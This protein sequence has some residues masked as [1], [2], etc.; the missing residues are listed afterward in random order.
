LRIAISGGT[1]FVGKAI[2]QDYVSKGHKVY[3]ITRKNGKSDQKNVTYLNISDQKIYETLDGIDALINLA[4]E[5][6]NSGRWTKKRKMRMISS[7]VQSTKKVISLLSSLKNKPSVFINA[8]AVGYY[9]NSLSKNFTEED[10]QSGEDFLAKT[11]Y[12]WEKEAEKANVLNIRTVYTRFGVILGHNGGALEKMVMPYKFFIGGKVGSGEQW[13]SWIHIEDVISMIQFIINNPT[14]N[15]P[16]NVTAPNPVK[17]NEFGQTVSKILQRPHWIPA[18]AIG[19]KLILGEMSDLVLK[20]QRV[21]PKKALHHG[22]NFKF[23]TLSSALNN[24]LKPKE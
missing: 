7:R 16:I 2:T 11:V 13:L 17:M 3:I 8:S 21:L 20:G 10:I 5:S 15:G 22:Y 1:G 6:I 18:P 12:L 9:G 23:S 4:G 24:L 14:I 19:L